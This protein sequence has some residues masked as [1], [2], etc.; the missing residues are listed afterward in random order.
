MSLPCIAE[1]SK[2]ECSWW[3]SNYHRLDT[4]TSEGEPHLKVA[5]MY[6]ADMHTI[7]KTTTIKTNG[8]LK[9][10]KDIEQIEKT[11]NLEYYQDKRIY[12]FPQ[13]N[14]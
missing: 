7:T 9:M 2:V 14:P 6:Q 10:M 5:Q 3:K 8:L 1:L 4:H 11:T 12:V 13:E